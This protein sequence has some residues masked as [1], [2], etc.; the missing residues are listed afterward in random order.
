VIGGAGLALDPIPFGAMPGLASLESRG[1][2]LATSTLMVPSRQA[3]VSQPQPSDRSARREGHD[4]RN[5]PA[6]ARLACHVGV[7]D[8]S[9]QEH[10]AAQI[11]L[12]WRRDDSV[13]SEEG[14]SG[15]SSEE[16]MAANA[17]TD[18]ERIQRWAEEHGARPACV[19]RT[20]GEGDVGIIRLDFPGYSGGDT[21]EEIDWDAWFEKFDRQQLALLVDEDGD[22]NFNKLVRR[23][24]AGNGSAGGRRAAAAAGV[25]GAAGRSAADDDEAADADLDE[26]DADLDDEDEDENGD[27]EDDDFD[28]DDE[29]FEGDD[30]EEDAADGEDDETKD[31]R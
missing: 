26:E 17:L 18:R 23:T 25:G 8:R 19:K 24:A 6:A 14:T 22:S 16:T 10:D 29:D 20:G 12:D 11:P 7:S 27:E 31:D 4:A 30:E 13:T 2:L 21:L 1:V 5:A 15:I 28:D 3:D 9:T